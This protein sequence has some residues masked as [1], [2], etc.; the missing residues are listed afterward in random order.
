MRTS[1]MKLVECNFHWISGLMLGVEML[2]FGDIP[3]ESVKWG[4]VFDMGIMRLMILF[5]EV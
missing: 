4:I 3:D 2:A 1:K 5:R